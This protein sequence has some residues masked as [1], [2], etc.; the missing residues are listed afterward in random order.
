[1]GSL[2]KITGAILLASVLLLSPVLPLSADRKPLTQPVL[3]KIVHSPT[4]VRLKRDPKTD[5]WVEYKLD[6]DI[7]YEEKTGNF[8]LRWTGADGRRKTVVYAPATRLNAQVAARVEYLP[9]LRGYRYLYQVSNLPTS[10]RKLH[11]FY[12]EAQA[13][14]EKVGAPD[15]SWG[16]SRPLTDYLQAQ[17]EVKAGW[18]WSQTREGREGLTP[19]ENAAGFSFVSAGLPAVMKCY[20]RHHAYMKGVGEELPEEL[21]AAIDR[22][23]WKIPSGV[24]V[25]P[26]T[27]PEPFHPAVFVRRIL[28]MVDVSAKQGWI[29]SPKV[30]LEFQAMLAQAE[31]ALVRKENARASVLLRRLLGRVEAEKGKTLLSEAYALLKFNVQYLES[32]LTASSH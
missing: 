10:Q 25:G 18:A 30:K 11:T 19:G 5:G 22:V 21:H 32:Q 8:L 27:P 6:G 20:I 9:D 31:E 29:E 3:K 28:E 13:P 4:G 23:A 2:G 26:A 16:Y 24:T 14:V 15:D 7:T 12:V 17:L 1:M